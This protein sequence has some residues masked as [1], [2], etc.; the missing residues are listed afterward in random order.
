MLDLHKLIF[1]MVIWVIFRFILEN[2]RMLKYIEGNQRMN[3]GSTRPN[4]PHMLGRYRRSGV[5]VEH[6]VFEVNSYDLYCQN[7]PTLCNKPL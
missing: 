3:P 6:T 7:N 5:N 1:F 4:G 2:M